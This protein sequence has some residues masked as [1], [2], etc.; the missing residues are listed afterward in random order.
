MG[1]IARRLG[2]SKDAVVARRR[3]LE[4]PSRRLR[5][6]CP[7]TEDRLLELADRA[8]IPVGAIASALRRSRGDVRARRQALRLPAPHRGR[9]Y[10]P[11]ED[12][13]LR[14]HGYAAG[15]SYEQIAH[16]LPKRSSGAVAARARRLGLCS[17]A[18]RW[19]TTDDARLRILTDISTPAQIARSLGRT[20]QA[21]RRRADILGMRLL[22][23]TADR[24]GARWAQAED[25]LLRLNPSLNPAVLAER[26]GRSDHA[27]TRRLR[28]LGL[29]AGRQ[30]SPTIRPAPSTG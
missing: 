12:A 10:S 4:I 20:P 16:D 13:L 11:L 19:T 1:D 26:L 25:D 27:V 28:S 23:R 8:G 24:S 21:I 9:R 3:A 5:R 2:R 30:R 6:P 18:R 15:L 29:R 17:Y 7:A 22:R 14:E